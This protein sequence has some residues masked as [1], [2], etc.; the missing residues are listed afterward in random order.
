MPISPDHL[1][2]YHLFFLTPESH[3]N[4]AVKNT[5]SFT[6]I[7]LHHNTNKQKKAC[8]GDPGAFTLHLCQTSTQEGVLLPRGWWAC[9]HPV[10]DLSRVYL[11]KILPL[12]SCA[13]THN[14]TKPLASKNTPHICFQTLALK[15]TDLFQCFYYV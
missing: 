2:L 5:L 1:V 3:K 15:S 13:D 8:A 14:L 11:R 10:M 9:L 7:T 12:E 6:A 4:G